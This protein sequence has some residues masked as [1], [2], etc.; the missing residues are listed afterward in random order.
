MVINWLEVF[1]AVICIGFV[2]VAIYAALV[3]REHKV[4]KSRQSAL[5]MIIV[6]AVLM[7]GMYVSRYYPDLVGFEKRLTGWMMVNF[8]QLLFYHRIIQMMVE[9]NRKGKYG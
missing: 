2:A 9:S 3:W 8:I 6:T 1:Q 7:V 5:A 4:P